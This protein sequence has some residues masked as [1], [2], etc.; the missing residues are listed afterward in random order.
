MNEITINPGSF[1]YS[2]D[3]E[4]IEVVDVVDHRVVVRWP[5]M[6]TTAYV[7]EYFDAWFAPYWSHD[8]DL[9]FAIAYDMHRC[10][11]SVDEIA[12]QIAPDFD[13]PVDHALAIVHELV[14][15]MVDRAYSMNR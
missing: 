10:G 14:D 5:D 13:V 2:P 12:Q 11:L 6:T 3:A 15:G 8:D 1:F 7:V 4:I 9:M